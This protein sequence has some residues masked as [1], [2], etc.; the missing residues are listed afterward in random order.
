MMSWHPGGLSTAGWVLVTGFM[1]A[2]LLLIVGGVVVW[3]V[4]QDRAARRDEDTSSG[5]S[6]DDLE[7]LEEWFAG[8]ERPATDRESLRKREPSSV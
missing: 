4:A 3:R 6:D 8:G 7:L 1:I 2:L 5:G